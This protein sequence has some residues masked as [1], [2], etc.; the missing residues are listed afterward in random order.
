[1]NIQNDGSDGSTSN[2][3]GGS[4]EDDSQEDEN[5]VAKQPPVSKKRKAEDEESS[6]PKKARSENT[7][8]P[9]GAT[10]NLF[11]GQLSWNVD[12]EWLRREFESFGEIIKSEVKTDMDSGRSKGFGFVEFAEI[13]DAVKAKEEMH[14]AQVDGRSIRTDYSQVRRQSNPRDNARDRAQRFGDRESAETDT[15][16]IGN[17][18]FEADDS[19]VRELFEQYGTITRVS[20]PTDQA[21]GSLKG[22]GYIG[23]AS[24]D[25]AKE[26]KAQLTGGEIAGRPFR[27]DFAAAR[28]NNGGGGGRGNFRGGRGGGRGGFGDRG[29][30]GGRGGRGDRGG[31]RGGSS[32]RGGVGAFQGRKTTF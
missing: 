31:G 22:F 27:L 3:D 6:E 20:L 12:D 23:F 25:E 2:S 7:N 9:P 10:T 14:E 13:A 11:V 5:E 16:F 1:M 18:S 30:R 17:L 28:P 24:V 15:L 26:A 19:M 29:G 32:N 21:T 8:I 4:S